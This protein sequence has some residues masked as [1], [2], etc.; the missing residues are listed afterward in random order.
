MD[1][2]CKIFPELSQKKNKSGATLFDGWRGVPFALVFGKDQRLAFRGH[3]T[4][5]PENEEKHYKYIG[6]LQAETC[7]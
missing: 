4:S 2:T 7:P 3:F 1:F 5:S 6:Q